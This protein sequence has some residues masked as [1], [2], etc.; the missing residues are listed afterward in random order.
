MAVADNRIIVVIGATG[1]QGGAVARC[2]LQDGWRVRALTRNA[3]SEKAQALASRGAEVVQGDMD[4]PASLKPIFDGAYG[5]Y[6]VQNSMVSGLE[7]EVRQGKNVADAA[8][9]AGVKHLVYGSTGPAHTRTGVGSW[10]SKLDVQAHMESLNLPTTIL[11]PMAFMELMTNKKF[12]PPVSAWHLMPKF[13]GETRIPWLSADDLGVIAAKA[14]ANPD[15]FIGKSL[16]LASDM[17][18]MGE[19]R[20]LYTEITGKKPPKFPMPIWMFKRFV[21]DD[22]LNMWR[23]LGANDEIAVNIEETRAIHPGVLT[24]QE[25]LSRQ[26]VS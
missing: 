3:R 4:D 19:C 26:K 6:S 17:K 18:S 8:M 1:L 7:G 14:F 23:W 12:F 2:L 22:L 9:H 11:R 10:D 16:P 21:G 13:I 15:E 24:V 20:V 25:W 5:V